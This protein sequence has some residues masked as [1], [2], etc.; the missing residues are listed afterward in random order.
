MMAGLT[1]GWL[2]T[3]MMAPL[4]TAQAPVP[5]NFLADKGNWTVTQGNKTCIMVTMAGQVSNDTRD[6][7]LIK[8]F[9]FL[10]SLSLIQNW[11]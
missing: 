5:D 1:P 6:E 8:C 4:V 9:I 11:R 7:T 10:V 3:I 2:V